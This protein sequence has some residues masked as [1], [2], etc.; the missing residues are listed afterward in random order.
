VYT[1]AIH[2]KRGC[3]FEGKCGAK[4][5]SLEGGKEREET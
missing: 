4:L 1:I 3:A 5:E 2:E